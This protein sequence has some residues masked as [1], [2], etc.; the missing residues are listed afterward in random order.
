M[1]ELRVEDALLYLDQ[2]KVEFGDRPHIYNEFLDIMKTFKT[3]QIDT[4]GVIRRVSNLFQG[5]RRL[6]LGFNTFLPE[7]YRIEIPMDGNGPP[8]AVY[9][10][11][12]SSVAHILRE[13]AESQA[14]SVS[15]QSAGGPPPQQQ[16]YHPGGMPG[17]GMPPQQRMLSPQGSMADHHAPGGLSYGPPPPSLNR[18]PQQAPK[19]PQHPMLPLNDAGG[20]VLRPMP[21]QQQQQQRPMDGG[22]GQHPQQLP[23]GVAPRMMGTTMQQMMN[24]NNN[25]QQ[26]GNPKDMMQLQAMQQQQ[27]QMAMSQPPPMQQVVGLPPTN[28]MSALDGS[29]FGSGVETMNAAPPAAVGGGGQPL[30]FDHA[31]NYVTTIKRRFASEPETYK[32][33]LEILHTYQ[34]E[35]RGIKEVLDEVSELFEDHPDL[36]KEFTF[37]LPDA[38]QA[39]AKMQLDQAAKESESRKRN[40][41]KAAIMNAA[42]AMQRQA[43]QQQST[44]NKPSHDIH[45][46]RGVAA[47]S[48]GPYQ[49]TPSSVPSRSSTFERENLI[50]RGARYGTVLFDPV[51]PPRKQQTT[52]VVKHGRPRTVPELPIAPTTTEEAFFQHAKEHL[53]RKELASDKPSG[54]RRHTPHSEFLKCLHLFGAGVLTKE[55]LTS[56]LRGLFLQGHAPKTGVNAGGGYHNPVVANSAAELMREFEEVL[57]GRGPYADQQ[58][59][60]KDKSKYGSLR[61]RDFDLQSAKQVS[62][63]YFTFPS[64]YPHALFL[65]HPGQTNMDESV[66]NSKVIC[67]ETTFSENGGSVRSTSGSGKHH[68]SSNGIKRKFCPSIEESDGSKQRCNIYEEIMFRIEDE[69]FELDMA[70][71]RNAHALRRMEPFAKEAQAFREQEEKDGQPIGRLRYQLH[72]SSLNTIHINA[73]GRIYGDRGDEILQHLLQNPLIVL[74]IV[75]QRLKQK[76]TE[77]RNARTELLDRWSAIVE[78]SYEGCLDTLCY[79]NRKAL[80]K[81]FSS[82]RL[83]EQCKKAR[84][85]ANHPEKIKDHP[86]TNFYAPT[87]GNSLSLSGALLFQPFMEVQFKVD[88][89][90]KIALDLIAQRIKHSSD[91][92]SFVRERIGRIFAEF[93]LP[94]FHYPVHWVNMEVRDSFSGAMN[95]SITKCTFDFDFLWSVHFLIS[96]LLLIISRVQLCRG[97]VCAQS[98]E[99]ALLHLSWTQVRNI[100]VQNIGLNSHSDLVISHQR[101]F[102]TPFRPKIISMYG[103][104]VLWLEM[105]RRFIDQMATL[106]S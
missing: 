88:T 81:S 79:F 57:I 18:Q 3:Q 34:K 73:I 75:Y 5:N 76:D 39:T 27:Q 86:A 10:A 100:Q 68:R 95:P 45:S 16:H 54:S 51:R 97:N 8:V 71:E 21:Q 37:F 84:S 85:F 28:S 63:S 44:N 98:L 6:V 56:L 83:L 96:H 7:G 102:C 94:W 47:P 67:V 105:S 70:I 93:L 25:M 15:Q 69:R 1:R 24:N 2:V 43:Q 61:I 20:V 82:S 32:K 12:G 72:R 101:Q 36:L 33:F 23:G 26:R 52:A 42:Q 99:K 78:A 53:N 89:S 64:D 30:E 29:S 9:R 58:G 31:I 87:F 19:P 40:K 38:V 4:P 90:H 91:V 14:V 103:A 17:A 65:S 80:E 77:W 74:P 104:M 13:S 22:M 49:Q 46:D 48:G 11:P 92:T 35:Q 106:K 66:L 60:Q 41:A 59:V 50:S 55:E 62:P